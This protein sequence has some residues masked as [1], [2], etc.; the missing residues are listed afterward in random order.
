MP[1]AMTRSAFVC[2]WL[3]A[4]A[5]LAMCACIANHAHASL[6]S[7]LQVTSPLLF[8][9][10]DCGRSLLSH[11]AAEIKRFDLGILNPIYERVG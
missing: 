11:G 7:D 5:W 8:K 1:S 9:L 10:S 3:C 4:R 6:S 2:V